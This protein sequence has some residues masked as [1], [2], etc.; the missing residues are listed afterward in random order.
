MQTSSLTSFFN[1]VPSDTACSDPSQVE[2]QV[3]ESKDNEGKEV[4]VESKNNEDKEVESNNKAAKGAKKL[5]AKATSTC[6][7]TTTNGGIHPLVH[8]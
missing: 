3:V 2:V 5:A 7:K 6:K 4:Q 1:K 8:V